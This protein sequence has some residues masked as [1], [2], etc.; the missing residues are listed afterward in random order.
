MRISR[1][2]MGLRLP[3]PRTSP[4]K[5]RI[6]PKTVKIE[7]A[8]KLSKNWLLLFCMIIASTIFDPF[9]TPQKILKPKCYSPKFQPTRQAKLFLFLSS[10]L[11][12]SRTPFIGRS[13][14][15]SVC[16]S[17]KKVSKTVKNCQKSSFKTTKVCTW[18]QI[19]F[20]GL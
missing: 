15:Q 7:K 10:G 6:N 3:T 1:Q 12:A 4:E 14:G 5:T 13:V 9:K 2:G 19:Y 17:V 20:T 18:V 16:R 11:G 8:D